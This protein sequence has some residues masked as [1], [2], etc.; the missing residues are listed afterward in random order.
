[1]PHSALARLILIALLTRIR[2]HGLLAMADCSTVNEG[3]AATAE[4]NRRIHY[5]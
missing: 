4:R 2:L 1:M 5:S 3:K